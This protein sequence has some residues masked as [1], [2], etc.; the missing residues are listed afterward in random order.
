MYCIDQT[1]NH[2]PESLND[3]SLQ[4]I[5]FVNSLIY[6]EGV[7]HRYCPFRSIREE[8]GTLQLVYS[9]A[10]QELFQAIDLG[11][12]SSSLVSGIQQQIIMN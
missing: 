5:Q 9:T 7:H 12:R 11:A 1:A 4:A 10:A 6:L 2:R 8:L 3:E